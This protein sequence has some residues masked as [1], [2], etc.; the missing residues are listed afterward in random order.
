MSW[1]QRAKARQSSDFVVIAAAGQPAAQAR[2]GYGAGDGA[3]TRPPPRPPAR[4]GTGWPAYAELSAGDPPGRASG[5]QAGH[6]AAATA[7]DGKV[8]CQAGRACPTGQ[9]LPD[10]VL[11]V[12]A[13]RPERRGA[14]PLHTDQFG[15]LRSQPAR[16]GCA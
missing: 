10:G 3:A 9:P 13:G 6:D 2:G 8:V 11:A 14:A 7:A 5:V 16:P 12:R 15:A 4:A 1:P